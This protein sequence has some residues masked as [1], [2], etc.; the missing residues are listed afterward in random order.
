MQRSIFL[1][2][3]FCLTCS[4]FLL[5]AQPATPDS[6][7]LKIQTADSLLS[8]S[9]LTKSAREP[10]I[11]FDS[12]QYRF[13]GDG[14]FTTGNVNRSLAVIR[15]EITYNGPIVSLTTHPRFTYGRQNGV[16]AERDTY[17]DLFVDIYKQKKLY[18]FGLGTLE[19]SNLRGITLRQ[20]AGAGLGLRLVQ[21]ARHT[22]SVTNAII[23]EST[24]FRERAPVSTLRN[25]ARLKG[26]H[27]FL[28]NRIRFNHLTFLQPSLNDISNLRWNTILSLELP[29][30]KWFALR[31]GF[32]NTYESVV[33]E[34]RRRNDSRITFGFSVGN[35]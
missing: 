1:V 19:T 31:A 29:L 25:S 16:Q 9:S 23:Y 3:L 26:T 6:D 5:S 21:N 32:E 15:A 22:L 12:L 13:S 33:D 14:N 30:S 20:L 7:S 34:T 10:F 28:Q 24:D 2:C 8:Q 11:H 18:G 17:V 4:S 27:S 35:K